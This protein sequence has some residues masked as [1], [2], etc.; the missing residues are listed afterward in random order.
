M[1][2]L[3]QLFLCKTYPRTGFGKGLSVLGISLFS[4]IEALLQRAL[5]DLSTT[6]AD[7]RRFCMPN[8][9]IR[10]ILAAGLIAEAASAAKLVF[11]WGIA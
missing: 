3:S 2:D 8:A 5:H 11:L 4:T 7:I 6:V 10:F 9:K 1:I